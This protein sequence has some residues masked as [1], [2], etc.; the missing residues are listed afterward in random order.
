MRQY[1]IT[2]YD[3]TQAKRKLKET[4]K[5]KL[6]KLIKVKLDEFVKD[7]KAGTHLFWL[8]GPSSCCSQ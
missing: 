1:E 2:C 5:T 4:A 7:L 3:E 8:E 6:L